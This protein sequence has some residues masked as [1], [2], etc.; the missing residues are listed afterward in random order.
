MIAL[1]AQALPAA[2]TAAGEPAF[3]ARSEYDQVF[4]GAIWLLL[5]LAV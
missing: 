2:L 4:P 5:R 3:S 1:F